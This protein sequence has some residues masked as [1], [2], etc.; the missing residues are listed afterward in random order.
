MEVRVKRDERNV[1][2]EFDKEAKVLS[3]TVF[4]GVKEAKRIL[5]HKVDKGFSAD[6]KEYIKGL[7]KGLGFDLNDTV[8]FLTAAEIEKSFVLKN[9]D[10]ILLAATVS[11]RPLACIDDNF[12][13]ERKISTTNIFLGI[14]Y[15][16][17]LRSLAELLSLVSAVKSLAFSDLCFS[18]SPSKRSFQSI[19]DATAVASFGEG[20]VRDFMGPATEVGSRISKLVY[21]TL[22]EKLLEDLSD[23]AKLK[24]IIGLRKED[25]VNL[26]LKFYRRAPVPQVPEEKVKNLI[27]E[28]IKS[29][30][31][32]PNVWALISSYKCPE[33]LSHLGWIPGLSRE[34][35]K[36]D[37]TKIVADEVL[38]I[39]LSLYINGIRGLLAYYWIDRTKDKVDVINE[40]PMFL[41]DIVS[42]LIGSV[43]SK[44]YD[45]ILS[46]RK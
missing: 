38:G 24:N 45:R 4:G 18:C 11:F 25:L 2:V 8:V 34:E 39:A 16:V 37:T 36:S 13:V 5:F 42:A 22:I 41:D 44:V 43:L 10:D 21:W 27:V 33:I 3:T 23:D 17:S 32:D 12:N 28:I 15:D 7:S 29:E 40:M 6:P 9:N 14:R 20:K 1:M 30:L 19:V 46:E 35:Y 26:S 31:K